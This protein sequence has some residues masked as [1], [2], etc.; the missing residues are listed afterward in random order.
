MKYTN[1]CGQDFKRK[2]DAYKC[3]RKLVR[4]SI[5]LFQQPNVVLLTEETPLKK[6]YLMKITK[7]YG[8]WTNEWFL[9]KTLGGQK[10]TDWCLMSRK[11]RLGA[12]SELKAAV[13]F[14]KRGFH[15]S[16]SLD[17]QCPFDLVI[18]NEKGESC[19]IDVKTKSFR[20]K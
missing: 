7:N 17:P 3:F 20:K 19:L 4:Q 5:P 18:T 6:S 14:M 10:I 11:S 12:A 9:R 16:R 2:E 13:E 15:V 8:S 1:I